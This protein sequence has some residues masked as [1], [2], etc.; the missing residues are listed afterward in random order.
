LK[1]MVSVLPITDLHACNHTFINIIVHRIGR[2]GRCGKT[3]IATTFINKM[4]G[5]CVHFTFCIGPT[6]DDHTVFGTSRQTFITRW[7]SV[8]GSLGW[9]AVDKESDNVVG[10]RIAGNFR[11]RII[12]RIDEKEDFAEKT[13]VDLCSCMGVTMDT[14]LSFR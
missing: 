10:Y 7:I 1:T 4:C 12:S 9:T 13:F 6:T 2:T 14:L 5:K 3:G 11:G 8:P